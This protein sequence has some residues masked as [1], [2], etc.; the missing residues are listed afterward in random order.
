MEKW[1]LA[2][3]N[4]TKQQKGAGLELKALPFKPGHS[5]SDG[6][7]NPF[8][9]CEAVHFALVTLLSQFVE[10]VLSRR[11]LDQKGLPPQY[12]KTGESLDR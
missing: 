2:C 8:A 9:S 4:T 11:R 7:R 10:V 5:Y 12:S 6:V 1:N 3:C